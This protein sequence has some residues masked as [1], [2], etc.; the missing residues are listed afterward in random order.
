MGLPY[1]LCSVLSSLLEGVPCS[2]SEDG[3]HCSQGL[4]RSGVVATV[5]AYSFKLLSAGLFGWWCCSLFP[6]LIPFGVAYRADPSAVCVRLLPILGVG[7]PTCDGA[8]RVSPSDCV[9]WG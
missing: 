9:C 3:F 2:S 1:V 4:A 7:V 6:V 8:S 5:F